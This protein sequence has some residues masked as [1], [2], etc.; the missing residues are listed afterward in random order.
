MINLFHDV[1]ARAHE[2]I[3]TELLVRKGVRS[4]GSSP[5]GSP[6]QQINHMIRIMMNGSCFSPARRVCGSKAKES[7]IFVRVTM[8]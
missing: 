1:P 4:S 8:S 2:E 3:V 5:L 6:R 7:V